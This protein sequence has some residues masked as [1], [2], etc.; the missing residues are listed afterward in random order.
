MEPQFVLKY[1]N[2]IGITAAKYKGSTITTLK[3]GRVFNLFKMIIMYYHQR[4]VLIHFIT[5][6]SMDITEAFSRST[7]SAFSQGFVSVNSDQPFFNAEL[8]ILI[9]IIYCKRNVDLMNNMLKLSRLMNSFDS[10]FTKKCANACQSLKVLILLTLMCFVSDFFVSMEPSLLALFWY[11]NFSIPY[12]INISMIGYAFIIIKLLSCTQRTIND[13]LEQQKIK[14]EHGD[15]DSISC[16]L[17]AITMRN[18]QLQLVVKQAVKTL[19]P[20]LAVVLFYF[21]VQIAFQVTKK[22]HCLFKILSLETLYRSIL[23]QLKSPKI[24]DSYCRCS[25]S[26]FQC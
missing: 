12:I 7:I 14:L 11:I 5:H 18:K 17:N 13:D 8:T 23:L 6:I 21:G 16:T 1:F 22:L 24:L 4:I 26:L 2:L 19:S 25:F 15:I 20:P 9:Q 3:F 10:N